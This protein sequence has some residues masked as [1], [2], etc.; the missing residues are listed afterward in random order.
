MIKFKSKL[1]Q[2]ATTFCLSTLAYAQVGVNITKPEG[3]LH[4]QNIPS[5]QMGLVMPRVDSSDVAVNN[6]N[7]T[8]VEATVIYDNKDRCLKL[9]TTGDTK[10]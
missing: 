5:K 7:T 3:V 9:K 6:S 8:P 10:E 4:L 2:W 1:L